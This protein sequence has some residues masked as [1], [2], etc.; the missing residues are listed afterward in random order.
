M[1]PRRQTTRGTNILG[2]R[3]REAR[4]RIRPIVTQGDL[5]ARLGILGI[6]LDRPSIT[7]IESGKRYL[8]DYEIAAIARVLRVRVSWLFREG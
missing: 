3:V 5:A 8:R 6:D 7:R 2:K 1:A 4:E